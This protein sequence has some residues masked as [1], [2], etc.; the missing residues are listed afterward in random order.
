MRQQQES[1]PAVAR[2]LCKLQAPCKHGQVL[3]KPRPS[4]QTS[5][6]AGLPLTPNTKA[7]AESS[8]CT[9]RDFLREGQQPRRHRLVCCQEALVHPN[10]RKFRG[11]SR[12]S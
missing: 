1:K 7:E 11:S 5:G 6:K 9:F 4:A 12:I 2:S 3:E 10:L 8:S